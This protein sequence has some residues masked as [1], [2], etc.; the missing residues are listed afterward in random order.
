[1]LDIRSSGIVARDGISINLQVTVVTENVDFTPQLVVD[2]PLISM[3]G[4]IIAI[5]VITIIVIEN[6]RNRLSFGK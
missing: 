4:I 1:M 3:T 5:G 6:L 2:D